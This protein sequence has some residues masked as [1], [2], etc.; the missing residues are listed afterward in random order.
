MMKLIVMLLVVFSFFSN[1]TN[2]YGFEVCLSSNPTIQEKQAAKELCSYI[3]KMTGTA[4]KITSG[5]KTSKEP[6][7]FLG[8]N[9]I[10]DNAGLETKSFKPDEWH[11]KSVPGGLLLIGEGTRGTLYA[12][13]HYLEDICGVRWW[14][15]WETFVPQLKSLKLEKLNLSGVPTFKFRDIHAVY[16]RDKGHFASHIRLNRD[17]H[18]PIANIYSGAQVFGPPYQCHTFRMYIPSS[19]YFKT[20]PEWFSFR[21]GKRTGKSSQ[22]CL[23]NPELRKEVI[24]KLR[25]FIKQ[26]EDRAKKAN[27]L[28][29]VIYDISQNDNQNYCKCPKCQA[30]V[31]RQGSRAGLMI[32]FINEIANAI[33]KDYPNIYINTFAY[34][35]TEKIPLTIRPAKN[36]I[37]TLCDTRSNATFPISPKQNAYFYKLLKKWSTIAPQLRL[38]DYA[39]T[40]QKPVCLPYPSVDTYAKDARLFADSGVFYVFCELEEPVLADARDY[41]VWMLAKLYE[42]ANASFKKL[43]KDFTN[44]FYGPAGEL[45]RKYRACLRKSQNKKHAF[46]G[47]YPPAAAFSFLDCATLAAC[48]KIFEE[49]EKLLSGNEKLLRRWNFAFLSLHRAIC[50]RKRNLMRE[51]YRKHKTLKGFPFNIENSIER[52]RK[53]WTEQARIRLAGK[54]LKK[55]LALMEKE[56]KKYASLITK[57]S[58]EVPKRFRKLPSNRVFDFLAI[59]AI[60]WKNIVKLVKDPEAESGMACRLGFPNEGGETQRLAKYKLPLK[61]GVYSPG[62]Q[63][64]PCGGIIR[65]RQVPAS[66]Y[67]WYKLRTS[68]ITADSFMFFFWSWYIKLDI[69]EAF[70]LNYPKQKFDIW[71]RVKFTGPAFPKGKKSDPNAIYLE[72]VILVKK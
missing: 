62:T 10:A 40:F 72:R 67:H 5:E 43:A 29:P 57:E 17:G 38:W 65:A 22:L 64:Y 37:I 2:V 35:Y 50:A 32:D 69:S 13:Y 47:M 4:P 6:T 12:A 11:I 28:P 21:N 51:W 52:I 39:I 19:K 20:H 9:A 71:A 49:G 27:K 68:F 53:T 46:I 8:L 14:N 63:S 59:S 54:E 31:R 24:K 56:F 1:I 45:F 3:K 44:G 55:S 30:I 60:R 15:P 36:V 34:Q 23:S 18:S 66:G 48:Q 58:L 61:C 70:N 26:G 25:Y 16:G 33:K 41:K 42:N 7:I